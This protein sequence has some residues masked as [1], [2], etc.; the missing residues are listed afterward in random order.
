MLL[1]LFFGYQAY[2]DV[3]FEDTFDR[4]LTGWT[5][6]QPEGSIA[7]G[8]PMGWYYDAQRGGFSENSN[9]YYDSALSNSVML[10]NDTLVIDDEF[11]FTARINAGDDDGFGL[12]FGYQDTTDF[13]RV[14]FGV[15]DRFDP[16][17]G[18]AFPGTGWRVERK[19]PGG[20]PEAGNTDV[21]F[22][23][24]SEGFTPDDQTFLVT[25][26]QPFIVTISVSTENKLTLTI[27]DNPDDPENSV[28]YLVVDNQDL[29]SLAGGQVGLTSWGMAGSWFLILVWTTSMTLW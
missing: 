29:P 3:L 1:C 24:G 16:D 18:F 27:L 14:M 23:N 19:H 28:E 12:I 22:G 7:G 2:P 5:A 13:Y 11:I 17:T 20:P 26:G 15:Q 4:G 6:I 9:I 21:L 25:K 10:I 8:G